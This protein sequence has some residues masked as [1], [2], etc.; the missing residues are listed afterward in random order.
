M[1]F[2][3]AL[4]A[5]VLATAAAGVAFADTELHREHSFTAR[6]G[7]TVV[8]DVSMHRVEVTARPG[9]TVEAVVDISTGGSGRKAARMIQELT[10]VFE[11]RGDTLLIRS[12]KK[13]G[14][15][16]VSGNV[17]GHVVV[18]MPADLDLTID[19]SSGSITVDGDF[20]DGRVSCDVSS[21]SVTVRGAMRELAVDSSSGSVEAE[22][23]RPLE[24]FAADASSGS[25]SLSG[26]A[27]TTVVGT[28]SGSI[29]LTGLLG[30]ARM[31]AS[32]GGIT[33]QWDSIPPGA[34]IEADASSGGITI[35]LPAGTVVAGTASTGS[36]SMRTDFPG[37][38]DD[39]EI[40]FTGG[41]GAVDVSIDTSSGSVKVLA[42]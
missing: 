16:W 22:V 40:E 1:R 15:G 18:N 5:F 33:A 12:T 42:E 37:T 17:K 27:R 19:S 20:G 38:Y 30:D 6:P 36:G 4:A 14:W 23:D 21:G 28:S 2:R 25:V 31:D 29:S 41:A 10:P 8:I 11:D 26:G 9:N 13:G 34:S 32:S 7:Q 24:R 35:R 3:F 39:D